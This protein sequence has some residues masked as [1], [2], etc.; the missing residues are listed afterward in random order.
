MCNALGIEPVITTT[1]TSTAEEF[2]GLVEYCYGNVRPTSSPRSMFARSLL[3]VW[4]FA[5]KDHHG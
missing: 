2:A 3:L 1:D 4:R 5:F